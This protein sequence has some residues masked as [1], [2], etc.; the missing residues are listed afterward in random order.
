MCREAALRA[1]ENL[2]NRLLDLTAR[3]RLINFKHPKTESLRII[4]E[5]PDKL[6]ETLLNDTKVRFKSI[7]RPTPE[8]LVA[9]KYTTIDEITGKPREYPTAKEWAKLQGFDT[10]YEALTPQKSAIATE[11]TAI[12]TLL[13]PDELEVRLG[14][15]RQTSESKIQEMG[16]NILYLAFGFLEWF[17]ND[18]DNNS[19]YLAP[20]FLVPVRLHKERGRTKYTIN[21]SGEDI[22]PNLSLREKLDIDFGMNLPDLDENTKPESYFES[23]RQL[24][25]EKKPYWNLHRYITLTLLNFNKLLMYLDLDSERWPEDENIIDHPVVKQFLS[26]DNTEQQ[27]EEDS[28]RNFGFGEEY[29]IDQIDDVHTKYP[30]IDDADSSQHS[31]LIDAI[32]GKNLVIEGP[33]GTGKSQTIANLIA[34]TMAQG[35]RVLFVA[36]K[37]VALEV[38]RRRLDEAGLGEFCLE[39]HSHKS[40]KRKVLEEVGTRLQEL[41]N[42]PNPED[43][44]DHITEYE[45]LKLELNNYAKLINKHWKETGET[46]HKIFMAA[47]RYRELIGIDPNVLHPEGYDGDNLQLANILRMRRNIEVFQ[48]VY[49]AVARQIDDNYELHH[50]PW[51]GVRNGNLQMFDLSHVLST[52][53]KWQDSL[54]N[55]NKERTQIAEDLICEKDMVADSLSVASALIEDI[56][57][58][59]SLKGD[60]LLDRLDA[61]RGKSLDEVQRYLELFE[62]IQ[63]DL[64]SLEKK[65]GSDVLQ[66]VLQDLPKVDNYLASSETLSQFVRETVDLVTLENAIIKLRKIKEQLAELDESLKQVQVAVGDDAAQHLSLTE[67]GLTEFGDFVDLVASLDLKYWELRNEQFHNEELD[68]LLSE[69]HKELDQLRALHDELNKLFDLAK[70]PD[71]DELRQIRETINAGGIF[72]W[73]KGSWREAREQVIDMAAN[74]QI[75]FFKF[76][77][78]YRLLE[79]VEG[80]IRRS[81][82]LNENKDYKEALGEHFNGFETDI[83]ALESLRNW[84]KKI[85]DTYG[86]LA[87]GQNPA[88]GNA[89]LDL[90]A[91]IAGALHSLSEQGVKKKL[92]DILSYLS[93]LKEQIF[94]PV[95]ELQNG[96]TLLIEGEEAIITGILA[97]VKDALKSCSLLVKDENISLGE[98]TNRISLLVLLREKVNEWKDK[99]ADHHIKE[100]FQG[101]ISLKIEVGVD[102]KSSISILRNTLAIASYIDRKLTN[103]NVRQ[104]IYNNPKAETFGMLT[105]LTERLKILMDA[106]KSAYD[107]FKQLVKLEPNDWV[108]NLS[109]TRLN[110]LIDR[111]NLAL[112]NSGTLQNWLD[113]V[114]LQNRVVKMRLGNLVT[115]VESRIIKI[116][117][118]DDAYEAGI[119]DVLAREILREEPVLRDFNGQTQE[120]LRDQ[121]KE[122]DKKL[123]E[124]QRKK[125]A[126][127]IDQYNQSIPEGTHSPLVK[128]RTELAL[129]KHECGKQRRHIPIRQL[130]KRAGKALVALK[131]CFMMGPMSVAQY[132]DPGKIKFDVV[133]MDEASQIKPQDALGSVARGVQLVVVGDPKQLPPTSFFE[134][135]IDDNEEDL[136]TTEESESIL[137][138]ALSMFPTRQLRWHYRSKHESLIAFSNHKFYDSNLVLFPS[139]YEVTSPRNFTSFDKE[140]NYGY[141]I[142]YSRVEDGCF[143]N[144]RNE[145]EAEVISEAVREHFARES[146]KTLGVVAMNIEQRQHIEDAIETLARGNDDFQRQLEEDRGQSESLFIKNLENVQ[147]DERDV[148]FISMTYGPQQPQGRV[149]QRFGPINTEVGWRRLNVLFT[150][151][152]ECM[153]I[154]SSMGPGDIIVGPGRLGVEALRD[155]LSFCE[156]G[157]LPLHIARETE[158][159]P[160]S[161]F[162]EAVIKKLQENRFECKPQVGVAG[163]FI[164]VGVINPDNPGSYLMGIECD[165][166][167][168]HRAKSARDRDRLRQQILEDLGWKIRR[169]WS[170]DWFKN[171][172]VALEPII[173]ELNSAKTERLEGFE[174]EMESET[175]EIE[176]QEIESETKEIESQEMESETQEIESQE[177]VYL[178]KEIELKKRLIEFDRTVIRIAL[179]NT[180][181][182]KRL[183]RPNMREALL[184]HKPTSKSEFLKSIPDYL[185]QSTAAEEARQYLDQVLQIIKSSMA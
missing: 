29:P 18:N 61:L 54:Q 37:L 67:A 165:G 141:G 69:L 50:H 118:I 78:L 104:R 114:R 152:K 110:K 120:T 15:L 75:V 116:Q 82:E 52:L 117:Q 84:Y 91:D 28:E 146:G 97:S 101:D 142:V 39:L 125:I 158:R 64:S 16:A 96:M 148:I 107:D 35:K 179:P 167:T 73:F 23:V 157:N 138:A 14:K 21:Y 175:R 131:P 88:L 130:L 102:N 163:Y 90:S 145:R 103:N 12:Q 53:Q 5:L 95:P 1:L 105:K 180:P 124:L 59:P 83:V 55:L 31:A 62:D 77:R 99:G 89:I 43:I 72:P 68:D 182:N 81:Q 45:E 63:Q 86:V 119:W 57:S 20:L 171:P 44:E 26:R 94:A 98:L 17:E 153:H 36:E 183:L 156:T 38:V 48:E 41:G 10:S 129:L 3:N 170:T 169:I 160:D 177:A 100:L 7:L 24:I 58:I 27:E 168:Y 32:K 8:E 9:Q 46:R 112:N 113:Y 108:E 74:N 150:R 185:R 139:P 151:A 92:S 140:A 2:R 93:T 85:R 159:Y 60:E 123:K 25:N 166:A 42:H 34:A 132:L 135:D 133:I 13:Y 173:Q 33:P 127:Q 128:E 51:Y 143:I 137:G 161:D 80:F 144:K 40:Q 115:A 71:H 174:Q 176:S 162:E 49:Q 66:E 22:I 19:P 30:L 154:F 155:F 164:D 76:S 134:H 4:N 184:Q 172:D 149:Y 147:G 70:L 6:V 106:Q 56:E 11:D 121:F 109:D 136:T 111:N 181:I 65:L 178:S 126:C 79:K 122:C 47:T 87:V